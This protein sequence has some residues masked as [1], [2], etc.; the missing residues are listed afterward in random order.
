MVLGLHQFRGDVVPI[1]V[2]AGWN[3][4]WI[5]ASLIACGFSAA[6]NALLVRIAP[7]RGW[8]VVPGHNRW[9]QRVVAQFGGV[10]IL[11]VASVMLLFLH[12]GRGLL[13]LLLLTVGM[14]LLGFVDDI[15]GL[16]PKPKLIIEVLLASLAVHAGV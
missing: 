14:A 6:L 4:P 7:A 5:W 8:V 12:P 13:N 1:V 10:P 11:F 2:L 15:I 16:G 9:N 3:L